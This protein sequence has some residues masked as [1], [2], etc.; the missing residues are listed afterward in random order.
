V[1]LCAAAVQARYVFGTD[2]GAG[3]LPKGVQLP[4]LAVLVY[5]TVPY[6]LYGT[7]Y[8]AFLFAD[9][10]SAGAAVVALVGAPFGLPAEYNLGMEL[11]LLTL[12]VA[13][14]GVEVAAALFARAFTTEAVR[15]IADGAGALIATMTRHHRRA[16][17]LVL[18]GF[19]ASA[20]VIGCLANAALPG[21]LSRRVWWTL[22]V[23]DL[24]YACLAIGL[25]NALV[26]FETRRAWTVA[27][28]FAAALAINLVTGYVLSHVLGG[29]HAVDGLVLGAAY[30]AVASTAAVRRT[31]QQP[32]YAYAA[33]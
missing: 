5:W 29:F 3:K 27:R 28:D 33:A 7:L 23:G 14:S 9:R 30:F 2:D 18:V 6:F 13:A 32:A 22:A 20:L 17:A 19:A 25:L 21:V 24:G 10:I 26:L 15:P 4:R 16:M 11:A 31:L 8:F 1:V 12:L